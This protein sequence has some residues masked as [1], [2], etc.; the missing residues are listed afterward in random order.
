LIEAMNVNTSGRPSAQTSFSPREY[1]EDRLNGDFS[2]RGV[3]YSL[4]GSRYNKWQYALRDRVLRRE[5]AGLHLDLSNAD[6]L[7]VGSGTGFYID[8]WLR[9]GV[10]SVSGCDLTETSVSRLRIQFPDQKFYQLDIGAD[11]PPEFSAR[12]DVISVFDVLFH[13]VDEVRFERAFRNISQLLVPGGILCFSELFLHHETERDL[14]V[15]FHSLSHI[16]TVLAQSGFE[17]IVRRPA[18][19]LMNEPRDTQSELA[20]FL[21]KLT[22]YPARKSEVLGW[23][24]GAALYPVDLLLTR[25]LSESPTTEV[26]FCRKIR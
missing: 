9:T 12:F 22:M 19:V 15:V 18:F 6:V 14:H 4:L 20:R 11:P 1:W 21:W 8:Y 16:E 13:I 23:L 10:G 25:L 7:D 5:L 2:L 17:I 26:M 24:W 3:G